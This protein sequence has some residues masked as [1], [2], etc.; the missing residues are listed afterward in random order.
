M[1]NALHSRYIISLHFYPQSPLH[2]GA[3]VDLFLSRVVLMDVGGAELPVIPAESIKGVL[4]SLAIR[5]A[6]TATF[7]LKK[8]DGLV[9]VDEVVKKHGKDT[10]NVKLQA[11]MVEKALLKLGIFTERQLRELSDDE[12]KELLVSLYCPICLLFGSPHQAGKLLF[13]DAIPVNEEGKIVYPKL[14]TQTCTSISRKT[15]TAEAKRLF[16]VQYVVPEEGISFR[17]KIIAENLRSGE[18]DAKL[19]ATVL[20]YITERGIILGGMKSRGFGQMK[21]KAEVIKMRLQK[22]AGRDDERTILQNV[23]ALLLKPEA[24]ERMTPQ[25]LAS[26]LEA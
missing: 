9:D 1:L 17:S 13:T 10:H 16:T 14:E 26:E 22:P 19:F 7:G 23:K 12:K 21:V 2:V 24:T 4:R 5:I 15:R 25:Q 8:H 3:G 6:R 20:R 18:P 11:D